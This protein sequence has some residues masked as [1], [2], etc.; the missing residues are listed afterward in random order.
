M[1]DAQ[2][3]A[4]E[5]DREAAAVTSMEGLVLHHDADI[6]QLKADVE[7]IAEIVAEILS[8]PTKT[9]PAP[10]NWKELKAEDRV[11]LMK[12]LGEW[13]TWIN[14]RYGVTDSSRIP[15]CWYHHG[16][17]VEEL[18]AAWVAWKAA[19]YGHKNPV[20]A[21]AYWHERILWPTLARIKSS[22]WGFSGC[23]TAH[24]DPRPSSRPSID[25]GFDEF[26]AELLS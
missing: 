11:K 17:V 18:T 6:L 20:D 9:Q 21:P 26:T 15:G 16:P 14:D 23:T 12:E 1:S 19:Y 25:P 7:G 5:Q 8:S 24:K 2:Q 3:F 10:W 13:V 4:D 22:S